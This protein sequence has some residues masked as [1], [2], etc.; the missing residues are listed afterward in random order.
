MNEQQIRK[1]INDKKINKINE[2]NV[3]DEG[4]RVYQKPLISVV[5]PCYN[6]EWSIRNCL[7]SLLTQDIKHPYEII[8]IDSS[9]DNTA[10]IIKEEFPTV[11]LIKL[12]QQT[13]PG[14]GRNIGIREAQGQV[15]AFIDSDCV[16]HS[17][18]L[19]KAF[20]NIEKGYSVVGG[21]IKN[22][23]KFSYIGVAD[24]V[25]TFNEFIPGTKRK[26]VG[27]MPSCNFI[28]KKDALKSVEGFPEDMITGEDT[29]FNYHLSR[30]YKL[31]FDPQVKV[32]HHGRTTF[33]KFFRHH[34]NFGAHSAIA[35]RRTNLPGQIFLNYPWLAFGLP[36]LR[37]VR[38]SY[39]LA[40]DNF[41]GLLQF[42]VTYPVIFA[43]MIVW[44]YGWY[45]EASRKKSN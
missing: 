8:V 23:D 13:Y 29:T 28:G 34:Y 6:A 44:S 17:R 14:I 26:E 35:R 33:R 36:F 43:G 15:I 21:E 45:K 31:L 5:V 42:I 3:G 37:S 24:H 38:I 7:Q 25:L 4:S 22:G 12:E 1:M 39:R 41:L 10:H 32:I 30:K 9:N 20:H 16:A 2:V 40:R 19:N 27:S 18:W 11:R